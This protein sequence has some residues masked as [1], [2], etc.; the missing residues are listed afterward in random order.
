MMPR[1]NAIKYGLTA[2]LDPASVLQWYHII[3]DDPGLELPLLGELHLA[4]CSALSLGHAALHL[5]RTLTTYDAFQV[6]PS[7]R[8]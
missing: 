3:L 5:R 2:K 7:M 6:G 4:Q 1:L 8:S